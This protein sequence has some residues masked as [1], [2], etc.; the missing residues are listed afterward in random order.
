M[1]RHHS[2]A[3][4]KGYKIPKQTRE[5]LLQYNF[6]GRIAYTTWKMLGPIK[7]FSR[8]NK[9]SGVWCRE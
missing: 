3:Q 6:Y 4:W 5:L 7:P 1:Q 2:S 8:I 9:Y